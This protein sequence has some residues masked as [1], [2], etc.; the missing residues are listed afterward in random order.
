MASYNR[1]NEKRRIFSELRR[2]QEEVI[3]SLCRLGSRPVSPKTQ[4]EQEKRIRREIANSN[5]RRRMQSIN[6]GFQSLRT[7]LPQHEGEK[8]SKAAILQQTTEYIYQLEQEKAR[9]LAQNCQLK[10]LLNY[11]LHIDSD[12]SSPESPLPKRKKTETESSD[13][14]IGSMSPIGDTEYISEEMKKEMVGLQMQSDKEHRIQVM[15]KEQTRTSETQRYP[16]QIRKT[17][18][19]NTPEDFNA[20]LPPLEQKQFPF[21]FPNG[22]SSSLSPGLQKTKNVF[23]SCPRSPTHHVEN[24]EDFS[25]KNLPIFS[26]HSINI[27]TCSSQLHI[28]GSSG[29]TSQTTTTAATEVCS[30]SMKP[31][32]TGETVHCI[33]SPQTYKVSSTSRQNLET[34][35]EAIRHLEGDHMFRDDPE[36]PRKLQ[37]EG[38]ISDDIASHES[39]F[40]FVPQKT[41]NIACDHEIIHYSSMKQS[42]P[43]VI[44][45]NH[46]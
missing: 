28:L 4:M 15:L 45:S 2:Q 40:N 7:L 1:N 6:A 24:S 35:V 43:G 18:P 12:G 30:S 34:I 13:E 8:L 20:D 16:G 36:P 26:P 37:S 27:E 25:G 38:I 41:S 11:Q 5:E 22:C 3:G 23:V 32:R 10:R 39:I 33:T 17:I 29:Q 19:Q 14:G 31:S 21:V 44:V 9:L 42:R 46:T